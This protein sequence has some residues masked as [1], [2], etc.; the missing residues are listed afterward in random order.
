MVIARKKLDAGLFQKLF[1]KYKGCGKYYKKYGGSYHCVILVTLG[2]SVG[3][4]ITQDQLAYVSSVYQSAGLFMPGIK[5]FREAL[6]TYEQGE[7]YE[8]DSMGLY[9][10]LSMRMLMSPLMGAGP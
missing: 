6:E 10:T 2:M 3:A 9:D 1:D 4:Q 7:P 8:W 5:Q